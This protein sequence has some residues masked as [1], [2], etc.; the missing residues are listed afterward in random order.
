MQHASQVRQFL[1]V[2]ANQWLYKTSG[3][4]IEKSKRSSAVCT[5]TQPWLHMQKGDRE[6]SA[7]LQFP[8]WF[9]VSGPSRVRAQ[10]S[11]RGFLCICGGNK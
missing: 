4:N 10:G 5:V 9:R 7:S 2:A 3:D 8:C 6:G 11:T 1:Q